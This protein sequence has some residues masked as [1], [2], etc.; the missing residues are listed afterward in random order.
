MNKNIHV[1]IAEDMEPIRKRYVK[2]LSETDDIEVIADVSNSEEAI[3][4]TILKQPDIILMDIEMEKKDAGLRASKELLLQFPDLKIIILTV[5]E[6]DELIYTAFQFGVCDYILKNAKQE[7]VVTSIRNVYEGRTPLRPELATKILG[8]F[9][10]VKAYESSF[11]YA[12]NIVTSLTETELEILK[13]LMKHTSR[14]D[15][16]RI[17]YVEMSTVKTQIRNILRKFNKKSIE[18]VIGMIDSMNLYDF[19]CRQSK[20]L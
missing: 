19:I 11:L 3:E 12:V 2:M 17:R 7:E 16:C 10:R 15:I 5:Y 18:E 8:E 14:K 20:D 4:Q 1:L 13:L 9:K 6:E